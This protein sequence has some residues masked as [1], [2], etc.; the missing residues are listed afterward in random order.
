MIRAADSQ[1]RNRLATWRAHEHRVF[2][3][4]YREA[5]WEQALTEA[6]ERSFLSS[7][8]ACMTWMLAERKP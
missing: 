5:A 2:V 6:R 3:R 7:L 8:M 1:P 4:A